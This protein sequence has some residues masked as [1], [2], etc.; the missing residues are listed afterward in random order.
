MN[1]KKCT[2]TIPEAGVFIHHDLYTTRNPT[3]YGPGYRPG[4]QIT[5][6]LVGPTGQRA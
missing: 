3:V 2:P 5:L 4:V 6:L 1:A